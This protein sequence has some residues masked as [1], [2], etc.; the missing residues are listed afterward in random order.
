MQKGE[1]TASP[2]DSP[3]MTPETETPPTVSVDAGAFG[4]WLVEFR[5]SLRGYGGTH[6]PCGECVG[7]CVSSY[8]ILVR[9]EDTQA[10]A[11]I[12]AQL[13][14]RVS[15]FGAGVKAMG[16]L[17]DGRCP[18]LRAGQCSIYSHRPQTCRDYDCRVFAAAGI[19]AGDTKPAINQRVREWRFT[20]ASEQDRAAHRA[21]RAAAT[22]ILEH[23][24]EFPEQRLPK[25]PSGIAVLAVKC[26]EVFLEDTL[27]GRS[28]ADVASAI[29]NAS[30]RFDESAQS[31]SRPVP[32]PGVT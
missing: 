27:T 24:A 28:A 15:S 22:F 9:P 8:S 29:A 30:R 25:N 26:H 7:C 16:Y 4:A 17:T 14:T 20:Y 5:E 10:L 23:H 12:P 31:R 32:K 1:V 2:N 21:V 18:M 3:F 19:D 13:L 6:V 11:A